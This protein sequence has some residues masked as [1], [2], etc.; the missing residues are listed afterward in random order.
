[1][2]TSERRALASQVK[3]VRLANDMTQAELAAAAQVSRQTLSDIEND[4]RVPQA[5]VLRRLLDVLGIE[6]RPSGHEDDTRMWLGLIGGAL[7][8]LPHDR[9]QIAGKKALDVVSAELVS[10]VGEVDEDVKPNFNYA[11]AAKKGTRKV[12]QA[13]HAE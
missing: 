6:Q 11:L 10:N 4:V 1:M 5:G 8:A 12:D 2:A 7:D 9:R 3:R 13:P